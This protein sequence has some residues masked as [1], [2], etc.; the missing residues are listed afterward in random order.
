M[1]DESTSGTSVLSL[2]TRVGTGDYPSWQVLLEL[3]PTLVNGD[4]LEVAMALAEGNGDVVGVPPVHPAFESG[5][6]LVSDP[7]AIRFVLQTNPSKFRA[8]DVSGSRDFGRIVRN[9]IVSLNDEEA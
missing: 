9:S 6:Y 1:P 7:D 4:L 5:V 8:L 2:N 3:L